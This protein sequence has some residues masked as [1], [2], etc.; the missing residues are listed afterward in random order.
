MNATADAPALP[1]DRRAQW[2]ARGSR[3]D[4]A[5]NGGGGAVYGIGMIGALVYFFQ[6][7]ATGRDKALA[8]PKAIFWPALLVY[9]ALKQLNG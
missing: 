8:A 3:P 7:A 4:G 5:S 2:K 1:V 6:S 9:K